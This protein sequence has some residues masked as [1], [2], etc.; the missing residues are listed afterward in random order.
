L[1]G[2][3]WL[4]SGALTIQPTDRHLGSVPPALLEGN[5]ETQERRLSTLLGP[6]ET[7]NLLSGSSDL[8]A[9][10][11]RTNRK[12]VRLVVVAVCFLRTAQWTR[13]S[14]ANRRPSGLFFVISVIEFLVLIRG[15]F[16]SFCVLV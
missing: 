6:E 7:G 4:T 15:S 13:A 11:A 3:R 9:T 5:D 12:V 8:R 2:H 10:T 14:I 1:R 16:R